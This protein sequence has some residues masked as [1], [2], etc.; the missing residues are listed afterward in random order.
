MSINATEVYRKT[1][2][3]QRRAHCAGLSSSDALPML[4]ARLAMREPDVA[5]SIL[6]RFEIELMDLLDLVR[7]AD[8]MTD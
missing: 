4:I 8:E 3:L 5:L 2:A 7:T 1:Q 6:S